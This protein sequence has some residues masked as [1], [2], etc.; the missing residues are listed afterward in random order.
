[1]RGLLSRPFS[2]VTVGQMVVGEAGIP[3]EPLPGPTVG[4]ADRLAVSVVDKRAPRPVVCGVAGDENSVEG[5]QDGDGGVT[6]PRR[7]GDGDDEQATDDGHRGEPAKCWHGHRFSCPL[8]GRCA[9][10]CIS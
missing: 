10:R 3:V 5:E 6:V 8:L 4:I 7:H 9:G 1:M 2:G